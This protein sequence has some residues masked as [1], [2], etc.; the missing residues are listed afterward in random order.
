MRKFAHITKSDNKVVNVFDWK[1]EKNPDLGEQNL[2]IDVTN[3]K[4]E[5]YIGYV[6]N[7]DNKNFKKPP[8]EIIEKEK[9]VQDIKSEI[10]AMLDELKDKVNNL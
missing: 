7:P 3:Y 9:T 5:I 10:L 4:E 1:E 6:Y 8:E 2:L